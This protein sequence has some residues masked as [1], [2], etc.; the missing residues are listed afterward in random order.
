VCRS[1]CG[2]DG[3]AAVWREGRRVA[4]QP[5]AVTGYVRLISDGK[6]EEQEPIHG[7]FRRFNNGTS[8][9]QETSDRHTLLLVTTR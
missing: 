4:S 2:F 6:F 5:A 7:G 9:V 1:R 3:H 8:V